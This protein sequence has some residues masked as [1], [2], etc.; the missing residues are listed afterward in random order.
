M[1]LHV[2]VLAVY[3]YLVH[4]YVIIVSPDTKKAMLLVI[5]GPSKVRIFGGVDSGWAFGLVREKKY[6]YEN[7]EGVSAS[8]G[9]EAGLPFR[10]HAADRQS[11]TAS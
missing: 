7:A 5:L 2:N 11:I 4:T 6:I 1:F 8:D 10:C 9:R 3:A